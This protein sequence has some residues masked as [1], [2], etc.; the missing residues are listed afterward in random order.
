MVGEED[1]DDGKE[2]NQDPRRRSC[3]T[4][5]ASFLGPSSCSSASRYHPANRGTKKSAVTCSKACEGDWV[6]LGLI[7]DACMQMLERR[8][9][10]GCNQFSPLFTA[11]GSNTIRRKG[12]SR[13]TRGGHDV[14]VG[15]GEGLQP[16]GQVVLRTGLDSS[17]KLFNTTTYFGDVKSSTSTGSWPSQCR[18]K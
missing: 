9:P 18:H 16:V 15:V 2:E 13:L 12:I 11:N 17:S 8:R 3:T 5:M 6:G 1:Q 4:G 14:G 10:L 7:V